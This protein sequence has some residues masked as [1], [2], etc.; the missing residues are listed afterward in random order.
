MKFKKKNSTINLHFTE[1]T[2]G[3]KRI[4]IRKRFV[5]PVVVIN[6]VSPVVRTGD[7]DR[8]RYRGS[9]VHGVLK[10]QYTVLFSGCVRYV[11]GISKKMT[12]VQV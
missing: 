2:I 8:I 12:S 10:A 4:S 9:G 3:V 6:D 5:S 7:I 1:I 11:D